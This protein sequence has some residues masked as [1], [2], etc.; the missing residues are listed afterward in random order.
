MATTTAAAAFVP[1]AAPPVLDD[2][3]P[4][5][6][7]PAT[8][9]APDHAVPMTTEAVKRFPAG[10]VEVDELLYFG[11]RAA[12]ATMVAEY[13][14][15]R[16][17][18]CTESPPPSDPDACDWL[19]P[20][21]GVD[22][23][24]LPL[25]DALDQPLPDALTKAAEFIG[26]TMAAN[27]E[28]AELREEMARAEAEAA[29]A[30]APGVERVADPNADDLGVVAPAA[31]SDASAAATAADD[32]ASPAWGAAMPPPPA[33]TTDGAPS[34]AN[35]APEAAG[36]GELCAEAKARLDAKRDRE[37][38]QA[39]AAQEAEERRQAALRPQ[40]VY[41]YC[42]AGASRSAAVVIG[43][44]MLRRETRLADAVA[45]FGPRARPNPG[46]V[47]QL[48]ELDVAMS[49][50]GTCSLDVDEYFLDQLCDTFPTVDPKDVE[51]VYVQAAK[52]DIVAA[53]DM[54]MRKSA[55]AQVG[56]DRHALMV[57]ALCTILE[58]EKPFLTRQH[59]QAAYDRSGQKR[60]A[61]LL[62][63]LG[64]SSKEAADKALLA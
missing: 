36:E 61:A 15:K 47:R 39:A 4:L 28:R 50:D 32:A 60:D 48:V 49:E 31:T 55:Q 63:L 1:A 33:T 34:D 64:L 7:G 9:D 16:V 58:K 25:R 37:A 38:A 41:V 52:R 14:V 10:V 21:A 46:F 3:A 5:A 62:K 26:D 56:R 27:A 8:T 44:L 13:G 40:A 57:N 17:V 43:Y 20:S 53:R 54:L 6:S 23:L 22:T 45:Q 42:H 35:A 12:L 19:A 59:V 30:R 24:H 29:A 11:P 18:R 51:R 2:A